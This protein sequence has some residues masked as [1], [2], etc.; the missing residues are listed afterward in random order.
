MP[1]D[2]GSGFWKRVAFGL[3]FVFQLW[4]AH[5]LGYL[6]HEYAHTLV[7][8]A[9][10]C[11]AN[12]LALDYGRLNFDNVVYLEDIDEDVDYAPIF[13]AG[14]G[15][16]AALIAVAGVLFGSGLFYLLSRR[17][18]TAAKA[19]GRRRLALFLY[20]LC[21]M[22]VGNLL[23][24]VPNRTFATHADMAT[25]ERGLKVSPWWIA[26]VLG[27]PFLVAVWHFCARILPEAMRYFFPGE[28]VGQIFLLFVSAYTLFEF[29]G[30][31]GFHRYGEVSHWIAAASMYGLF[32]L[33]MVLCWPRGGIA[34]TAKVAR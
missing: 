6:V 8:W 15:A 32:P 27:V 4:L 34:P 33:T 30:S 29:F 25:V 13:A 24:Y 11:K 26:V 22:N 5:A 31:S 20:L 9:F 2:R 1:S 17:L 28:R 12:P 3:G 23:S 18:Y 7:A 21:L 10:G 14:R 16:V 19:V